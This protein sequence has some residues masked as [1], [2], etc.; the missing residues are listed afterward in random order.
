MKYFIQL[1]YL[2]YAVSSCYADDLPVKIVYRDNSETDRYCGLYCIYHAGLLSDQEIA[3]EKLIHSKRLSGQF[4]S[5]PKN[6]VDTLREFDIPHRYLDQID[7]HDAV[8]IGGPI[9]LLIKNSP[10]APEPNHWV[11][12]LNVGINK[13]TFYDPSTGKLTISAA[14]MQ[15]LW[16]GT[17]IAV[18]SSQKEIVTAYW[19]GVMLKSL[20]C[21]GVIFFGI[22]AVALLA[23]RYPYFGLVGTSIILAASCQLFHPASFLHNVGVLNAERAADRPD[24]VPTIEPKTILEDRD[25][26]HIV[27][28][29][30]IFQYRYQH[31]SEAV[32]IPIS[33]SQWKIREL[34]A[35]VPKDQPIVFYCNSVQCGWAKVF[36]RYSI[37]HQY[38]NLYVLEVGLAGYV[39]AGGP[40]SS[41]R[42]P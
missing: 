10:E 27:D 28:V 21:V 19:S 39:E 9:V 38:E 4:G 15:S 3:L 7:Y 11:M 12:L 20:L 36:A 25:A 5:T 17:A 26:Y 23:Q 37:L 6:L 33:S 31:I 32:N 18:G 29:R 22:G 16:G 13:C 30:T 24:D 34:L 42:E 8:F 35:D 1:I 2:F 40:T 14:E 41:G